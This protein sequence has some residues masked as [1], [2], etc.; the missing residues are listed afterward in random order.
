MKMQNTNRL[1]L[2]CTVA[3]LLLAGPVLA[4]VTVQ[5]GIDVFETIGGNGTKVNVDL[6]AGFFCQG[7]PAFQADVDMQGVPLTTNPPGL[8]GTADTVIE[9]LKDAVLNP[10]DCADIPVTV[11]ALSLASTGTVQVPCPGTGIT[12]WRVNACTC[13]CCGPQA[14]ST[15]NICA[16]NDECGTAEGELRINVCLTFTE[17]S[18]GA[19]VGPVQEQVV[20]GINNMP[21]AAQGLAGQVQAKEAFMIDTNCDSLADLAVPCTTNFNPGISC[22]DQGTSC[23]GQYGHLTTCHENYGNPDAHDHCVNPVCDRKQ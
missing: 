3:L 1:T 11:R 15:L 4:Q 16:E 14:I 10:G 13:G 9:R 17:V 22:D 23:L 8:L 21:W 5:Q 12:T 2:L 6:P 20:L 18:T 19:K 7:S